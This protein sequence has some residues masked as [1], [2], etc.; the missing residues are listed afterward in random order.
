M[1]ID[2]G[3]DADTGRSIETRA[4]WRK[5]EPGIDWDQSDLHPM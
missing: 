2:R 5:P 1:R 4:I 3:Q